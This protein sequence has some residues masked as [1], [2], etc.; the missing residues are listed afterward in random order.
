MIDIISSSIRL[1]TFLREKTK[2]KVLYDFYFNVPKNDSNVYSYLRLLNHNFSR[3]GFYGFD[4]VA[5]I[6]KNN[7]KNPPNEIA[8]TIAKPISAYLDNQENYADIICSSKELGEIVEKYIDETIMNISNFPCLNISE[9]TLKLQQISNELSTAVLRSGLYSWL[10]D[11]RYIEILK[12]N[13][14]FVGTYEK[15]TEKWKNRPYSKDVINIINGLN[16]EQ[17]VVAYSIEN[18]NFVRFLIRNGIMQGFFFELFEITEDK[19]HKIKELNKDK[20]VHAIVLKT[21]MFFP[22]NQLM[23]FKYRYNGEVKYILARKVV[24]KFGSQEASTTISGYCYPTN[25]YNLFR[26]DDQKAL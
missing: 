21:N 19:I 15:Q 7:I 25:E 13:L 12:K 22:N 14:D 23:L 10:N 1:G 5:N 26:M 3:Y 20:N 16:K 8:P 6:I 17:K 4:C 2:Y 24:P 11:P 9:Q 18:I